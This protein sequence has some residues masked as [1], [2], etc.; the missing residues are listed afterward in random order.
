M[1]TLFRSAIRLQR[2]VARTGNVD[3]RSVLLTFLGGRPPLHPRARATGEASH[4][5]PDDAEV[6]HRRPRHAARSGR[7]TSGAHDFDEIYADFAAAKAAEQA[8]RCSQCGV[9]YC[10]THCP[11]HNNIP[12]WLR[13]TAEGRLEE[14]YEIA[15]A[16]N[17]FP[18]FSRPHLPAGPPLRGQL[19]HRAVGPR[20]R[21]HRLGRA[22][23]DRHRLGAGLGAADPPRPRSGPRAWASSARAPAG[24]ACADMLRR[25]GRAGHGLRPPRPAPAA[26]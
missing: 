16:T 4:G 1:L 17:N 24:L 23:P 7:P 26:C 8:S 19:R 14:A 13:L 18:E 5:R 22:L 11:L 3:D 2:S 9:P 21:H 6:R 20:H 10:Q 12:D 25:A 15:Q